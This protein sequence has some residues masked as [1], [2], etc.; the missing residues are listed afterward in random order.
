MRKIGRFRPSQ[1]ANPEQS[2]KARS[3][4]SYGP[5]GLSEVRKDI[6]T[7]AQQIWFKRA[8]KPM[9]TFLFDRLRETVAH[10]FI[11]AA[12]ASVLLPT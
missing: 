7:I 12:D 5:P 3:G 4:A 9:H 2:D 11:T 10:I 1:L 8:V 6:N